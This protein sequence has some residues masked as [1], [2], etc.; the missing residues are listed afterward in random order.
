VSR[1][2]AARPRRV[3]ALT[4]AVAALCAALVAGCGVRSTPVEHFGPPPQVPPTAPTG[5]P[6]EGRYHYLLYF[7]QLTTDAL[8]PVTRYT[9]SPVSP[10][11][12]VR[13]LMRGPIPSDPNYASLGGDQLPYEF[14][15]DPPRPNDQA[16]TMRV[17][18]PLYSLPEIAIQAITC[19]LNGEVLG[20]GN[21]LSYG[22]IYSDTE[23]VNWLSC[24]DVITAKRDLPSPTNRDAIK[25]A[26]T[27]YGLVSGLAGPDA[28]ANPLGMTAPRR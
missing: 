15:W 24:A 2:V 13:A 12:I 4:L 11:D 23:Q 22:L 26:P 9:N 27:V 19:S 7:R 21:S 18:L 10:T 5:R 25:L 3:R 6:A 17:E 14:V 1:A 28:P 16:Y 20:T 8:V